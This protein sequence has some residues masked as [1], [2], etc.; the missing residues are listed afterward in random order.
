M[1]ELTKLNNDG[2]TIMLVTHDVKVAA[3]CTRL[4]Y[5]VDGNIKGEYNIGRYENASKMSER[6]HALYEKYGARLVVPD[7]MLP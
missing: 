7:I 6:E 4:L 3:R 1:D 2:T 5:I